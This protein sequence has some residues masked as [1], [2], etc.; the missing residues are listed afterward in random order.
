MIRILVPP[1][2][3]GVADFAA[4]L[5]SR[6]SLATGRDVCVTSPQAGQRICE[7]GESV[8]LQYSGYG[9]QKRGVPLWLLKAVA[10]QRNEMKSFGVFFHELYAFGPPWTSAFWLSPVHRYIAA[11]LAALADYRITNRNASALWIDNRGGGNQTEVLPVFSTVGE[12]DSPMNSNHIERRD[13]VVFGSSGL[14][15]ETYL[16]FGERL[17]RMAQSTRCV[18]HDIGMPISDARVATILRSAMVVQHGLLPAPAVRAVLSQS[19]YGVVCYPKN[20]AAKSS[21]LAAYCAFEL[22]PILLAD[23]HETADG[24]VLNENYLGDFSDADSTSRRAQEIALCARHWYQLHDISSHIG[25]ILQKISENE[26]CC[27]VP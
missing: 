9:F 1:V 18:I 8:L 16:R 5:S 13:I 21:V 3:G 17:L 10:A 23:T 7:A 2:P 6:L 12:A 4:I 25:S 19:R 15:T 27:D 14:R 22:C 24:L 11:S 20:Y 26:Q